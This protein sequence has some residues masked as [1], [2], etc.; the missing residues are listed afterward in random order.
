MRQTLV[1]GLLFLLFTGCGV[2]RYTAEYEASLSE[3]RRPADAEQRYGAKEVTETDSSYT[4]EDEFV[5]SIWVPAD[6][7]FYVDIENKTE[8][9]IQIDW[10]QA[11]YVGPNGNSQRLIHGEVRRYQANQ[12]LPPTVIPAGGSVS[13]SIGSMEAFS[14]ELFPV[15]YSTST[16]D[17]SGVANFRQRVDAYEEREVQVLL[18][19][20]IEEEVNEY[21]F[22]FDVTDARVNKQ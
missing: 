8:N 13:K 5:K 18:P 19:L 2:S 4:F 14:G 16:T 9:S 15:S 20:K 1:I 11:A 12:S 10:N 7:V 3:V 21:T 22:T 17:T 6:G